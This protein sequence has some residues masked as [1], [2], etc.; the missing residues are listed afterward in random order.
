M[1]TSKQLRTSVICFASCLCG[2]LVAKT[3]LDETKN[4]SSLTLNLAQLPRTHQSIHSQ[5]NQLSTMAKS[6]NNNV[7]PEIF[8]EACSH[9]IL[10]FLRSNTLPA[11]TN[12]H[13]VLRI[14]A[15]HFLQLYHTFLDSMLDNKATKNDLDLLEYNIYM[16]RKLSDFK[17]AFDFID[18]KKEQISTDISNVFSIA[19]NKNQNEIIFEIDEKWF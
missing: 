13:H 8:V 16:E 14:Q 19:Y 6:S 18:F 9:G 10:S 3:R 15:A 4:H 12:T 11:N 7:N 1:L 2:A 5:M 17:L